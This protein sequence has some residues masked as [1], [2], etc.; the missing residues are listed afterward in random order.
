MA[1]QTYAGLCV[2]KAANLSKIPNGFDLIEAG[3]LPLVT[4]TGS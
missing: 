2:V 1:D 4:T 3:A